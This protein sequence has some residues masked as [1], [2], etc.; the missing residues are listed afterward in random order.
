MGYIPWV[1]QVVGKRESWRFGTDVRLEP[2]YGDSLCREWIASG[3]DILV[4]S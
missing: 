3:M 1:M 4:D 2:G